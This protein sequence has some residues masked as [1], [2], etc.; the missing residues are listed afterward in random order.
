MLFAVRFRETGIFPNFPGVEN[1]G[2]C[3]V[4]R[5]AWQ[6]VQPWWRRGTN[7]DVDDML[8]QSSNGVISWHYGGNYTPP[9]TNMTGWKNPPFE[10]LHFLLTMGICQCHVSFQ[11]CTS[12]WCC[13]VFFFF[14]GT[15][16]RLL[17]CCFFSSPTNASLRGTT[18]EQQQLRSSCQLHIGI[19]AYSIYGKWP[20]LCWFVVFGAWSRKI[21]RCLH[22]AN[23]ITFLPDWWRAIQK[24]RWNAKLSRPK[25]WG[26]ISVNEYNMPWGNLVTSDVVSRSQKSYGMAK[27]VQL[28]G[29]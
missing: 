3:Q 23:S 24:K 6:T 10:S 1:R 16:R 7:W 22:R 14:S 19:F 29:Y 9:K 13:A 17:T 12:G 20:R 25:S 15:A 11:G 26:Q 8:I 27:V 18:C 21:P 28:G 2:S 5:R 4:L